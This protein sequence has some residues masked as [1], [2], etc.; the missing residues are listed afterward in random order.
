MRA[1]GAE[2]ESRCCVWGLLLDHDS[3]PH[4]GGLERVCWRLALLLPCLLL[5]IHLLPHPFP[6]SSKAA[7][8]STKVAI[9][10]LLLVHPLIVV[11][12]EGPLVLRVVKST[13]ASQAILDLPERCRGKGST[14][15]LI[16]QAAEQIRNPSGKR[17][18][19]GTES[20]QH[21]KPVKMILG[22]WSSL[23]LKNGS[24][25]EARLAR[26]LT[27][28]KVLPE[29]LPTR[30][31]LGLVNQCDFFALIS[32]GHGRRSTGSGQE[33]T[34]EVAGQKGCFLGNQREKPKLRYFFAQ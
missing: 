28:G 6:A 9:L 31:L 33:T 30:Q 23:P 21:S 16:E 11:L 26:G 10:L 17:R 24:A 13:Q 5:R 19:D 4:S 29:P 32:N 7:R 14:S 3:H 34:K 15:S 25:N 27:V 18:S 2:C 12:P 22:S 1:R 8:R 20:W